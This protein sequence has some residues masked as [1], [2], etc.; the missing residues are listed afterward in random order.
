[1]PLALGLSITG[2]AVCAPNL[3]SFGGSTSAAAFGFGGRDGSPCE[4][5]A[6]C[7]GE[8]APGPACGSWRFFLHAG[9]ATTRSTRTYAAARRICTIR[10]R[11]AAAL[12]RLYASYVRRATSRPRAGASCCALEEETPLAPLLE[13]R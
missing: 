2:A 13:A 3:G 4:G 7:A 10:T 5:D 9:K 11:G 8:G 12:G 6:P 1:M